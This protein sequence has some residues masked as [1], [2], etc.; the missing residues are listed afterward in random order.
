MIQEKHAKQETQ[1]RDPRENTGF[2]APEREI[3]K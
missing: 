2:T 3:Q 1:A